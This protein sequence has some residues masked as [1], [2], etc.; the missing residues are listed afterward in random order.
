MS[1]P[2][3]DFA[4]L[5][6]FV[7]AVSP[8]VLAL[9]LQLIFGLHLM[10]E[11]LLHLMK[12]FLKLLLQMTRKKYYYLIVDP[13]FYYMFFFFLNASSVTIVLGFLVAMHNNETFAYKDDLKHLLLSCC[14]SN[15]PFPRSYPYS[16]LNPPQSS[17]YFPSAA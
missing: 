4:Q 5:Y 9:V 10:V 14:Q 7:C 17:F 12:L 8:V 11:L 2:V 16:P 6:V 3:T 15:N 1:E 13:I